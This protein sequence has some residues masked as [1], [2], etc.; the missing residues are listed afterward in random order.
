MRRSRI[1]PPSQ[2]KQHGVAERPS[3]GGQEVE[4]KFVPYSVTGN[5]AYIQ[6][7]FLLTSI[8]KNKK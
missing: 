6:I 2:K 5:K 1:F 7:L 8:F 3:P 4:A